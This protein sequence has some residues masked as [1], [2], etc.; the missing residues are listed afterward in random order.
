MALRDKLHAFTGI[1]TR[2]QISCNVKQVSFVD[3]MLATSN[4]QPSYT[5]EGRERI[6]LTKTKKKHPFSFTMIA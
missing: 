4:A 5:T 3:N 6:T 1:Q 2:V